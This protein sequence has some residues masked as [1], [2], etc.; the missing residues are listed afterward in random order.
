MQ[1]IEQ[2]IQE[3]EQQQWYRQLHW[4]EYGAEFLGT[5]FTGGSGI[6]PVYRERARCADG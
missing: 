3:I 4:P 1:K 2:D 6:P 5:G